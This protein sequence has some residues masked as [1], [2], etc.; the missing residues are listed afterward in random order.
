VGA[1]ANSRRE[2]SGNVIVIMAVL[3]ACKKTRLVPRFVMVKDWCGRARATDQVSVV[4]RVVRG[5]ITMM[6][7]P[8]LVA[9]E[10]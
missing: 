3:P 10:R 1:C 2:P 8:I 9:C 7:F 5:V 6:P 4:V